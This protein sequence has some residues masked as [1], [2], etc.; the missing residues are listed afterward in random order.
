MPTK[1]MVIVLI[2]D[3]SSALLEPKIDMKVILDPRMCEI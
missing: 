2:Y 1:C 3:N